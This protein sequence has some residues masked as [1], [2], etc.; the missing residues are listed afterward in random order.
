MNKEVDWLLQEKYHG[1]KTAVFL[2]DCAR[3]EAGEPLSYLIGHLP[4]LDTTI[5]LDSRPLIPRSETEYWVQQLAK[6]IDRNFNGVGETE[7]RPLS[8]LDLCAGSGC[9]GVAL[10]K[11]FPSASVSFAEIDPAHLLTIK[12]NIEHNL[13][14]NLDSNHKPYQIIESDLFQSLPKDKRYHYIISNPPYIDPSVDRATASVKT[15]EPHLALYGGEVGLALIAEILADAPNFLCNKGEL[16]LEHE[17]EQTAD[18]HRLAGAIYTVTTMKD[19][20]ALERY[21]RLVLQ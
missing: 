10:A 12:K 16:W 2:T 11:S 6:E 20:Y 7:P 18:I 8:I 17:P 3:L 19:Q 1:E 9:I 21:S 14:I 4:F 13:A 15:Y 5:Y